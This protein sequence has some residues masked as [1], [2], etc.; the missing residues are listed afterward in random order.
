MGLQRRL[1][2]LSPL[3][4]LNRGYAVV[5]Q[6]DGSLVRS[7]AQV[8][9]GDELNVRISDGEFSAQVTEG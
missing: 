7:T 2:A 8:Q 5:S 1:E 9:T 6:P 3:A 4:I